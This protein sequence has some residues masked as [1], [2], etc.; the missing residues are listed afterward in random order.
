LTKPLNQSVGAAIN[1]V[2]DD[3]QVRRSLTGSV[4]GIRVRGLATKANAPQE[5][6]NIRV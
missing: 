6:P 4:A 5:V 2:D 3:M 1:I